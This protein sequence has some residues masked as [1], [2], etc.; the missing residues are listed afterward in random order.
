MLAPVSRTAAATL[1]AHGRTRQL[2]PSELLIPH[3]RA[4]AIL[5]QPCGPPPASEDP[6][7]S[8]LSTLGYCPAATAPL[9]SCGL[10]ML[11]RH[12]R[13]LPPPAGVSTGSTSLS[14]LFCRQLFHRRSF[15]SA[16]TEPRSPQVSAAR[17]SWPA[18]AAAFGRR[19]T[20]ASTSLCHL[21]SSAADTPAAEP[22]SAVP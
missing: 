1:A 22:P 4:A 13:H 19:P 17:T 20:R 14:T 18:A 15:L 6:P 5:G 2:G 12:H 11:Q 21:P 3:E 8:P 7:P 9:S 16:G 10:G